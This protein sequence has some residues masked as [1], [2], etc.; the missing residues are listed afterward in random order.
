M[1]QIVILGF[2][3]LLEPDFF[4]YSE[5]TIQSIS[6]QYNLDGSVKVVAPPLP[7]GRFAAIDS[8]VAE[9]QNR[10]ANHKKSQIV[11]D[12]VEDVRP[13]K[14]KKPSAMAYSTEYQRSFSG[15]ER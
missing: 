14:S 12:E 9:G 7:F 4:W 15:E 13:S 1:G 8:V 3:D 2:V 6:D 5:W 10:M 11:F